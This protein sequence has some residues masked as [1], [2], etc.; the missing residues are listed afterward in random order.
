MNAGA[1]DVMTMNEDLDERLRE[2]SA[3][4]LGIDADIL[5][6]DSSPDTVGDWTSLR[7]LSLIAA[8]EEEFAVQFS[9]ADI[10]SSVRF[11]A[12]RQIVAERLRQR[13]GRA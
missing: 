8:V 3:S 9:L 2:L 6:A 10:N 1:V 4:I 11:G 5:T 12:L 7:H 13:S